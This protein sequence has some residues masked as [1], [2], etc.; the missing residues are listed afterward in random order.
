G[1]AEGK[2]SG[3][4][5]RLA[6]NLTVM[7]CREWLCNAARIILRDFGRLGGTKLRLLPITPQNRAQHV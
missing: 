3:A 4:G 1:N 2:K 6:L 5:G 7:Q